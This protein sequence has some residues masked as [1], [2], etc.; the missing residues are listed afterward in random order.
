MTTTGKECYR[1]LRSLCNCE[2]NKQGALQIGPKF[3]VNGEELQPTIYHNCATTSISASKRQMMEVPHPDK[4]IVERFRRWFV[5]KEMPFIK[6]ILDE[7]FYDCHT[8]WYNHLRAQ[9][10]KDFGEYTL[11]MQNQIEYETKRRRNRRRYKNFGKKERLP[12]FIDQPKTRNISNPEDH[13]KFTMGS[14]IYTLEHIFTHHYPGYCGH[15]NHEQIKTFYEDSYRESFSRTV[16]IDYSAYDTTQYAEL[17]DV[18]DNAIYNH[19]APKVTHIDPETFRSIS[20]NLLSTTAVN[21]YVDNHV[22]TLLTFDQTGRVKSGDMSTTW[23][24][25]TRNITYLKFALSQVGYEINRDFRLIAKGDDGLLLLHDRVDEKQIKIAFNLVFCNKADKNKGLGQILKVTKTGEYNDIEFCSTSVIQTL[26][27]FIISRQFNRFFQLTPYC[28]SIVQYNNPHVRKYITYAIAE[29]ALMWAR[30]LPIFDVYYRKILEHNKDYDKKIV[31]KYL[32]KITTAKKHKDVPQGE[33]L[34]EYLFQ[35]KE[36]KPIS[37]LIKNMQYHLQTDTQQTYDRDD[38]Q[39]F[40]DWIYR[41]Y[42]YSKIEID[43]LESRIKNAYIYD[44][45]DLTDYAE[46]LKY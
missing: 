16:S 22:E 43:E 10:Q 25:T 6:S 35:H 38:I 11:Q 20:T 14:V 39:C 12:N 21:T 41:K 7:H 8:Y 27:G 42:G 23:G 24:N 36:V 31:D 46:F 40:Y 1:H 32:G 9:Q 4:H 28:E 13:V 19:L 26:K 29:S 5:T 15:K 44:T 3:S 2:K 34:Y 17:I 30:G 45:I 18:V 37:L 33:L